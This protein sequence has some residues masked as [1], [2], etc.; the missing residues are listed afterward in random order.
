MNAHRHSLSTLLLC[1]L[2]LLIPNAPAQAGSA[3]WNLNPTSGDWHTAANWTPNTVPNGPTDIATFDV[4]TTTDITSAPGTGSIEVDSIVFNPGASAYTITVPWYL[5]EFNYYLYI[6]GTGIVNNSGVL[7]TF[8]S[9]DGDAPVFGKN[10]TAG[11]LTVFLNPAV[12]QLGRSGGRALFG[13]TSNAGSAM[14]INNG[15]GGAAGGHTEFY[16]NSSAANATIINQGSP[17]GDGEGGETF[18]FENANAGTATIINEG[19][20]VAGSYGGFTRFDNAS[21]TADATVINEG[22]SVEGAQGGSSDFLL[23]ASPGNATFIADG[24]LPG[25]AAGRIF[26]KDSS[27]GTE[28]RIELFGTGTLEISTRY[29]SDMAV[30]SLEGDGLVF[31]GSKHFIVGN[32]GLSTVFS[33][34]IQDGGVGGG[35]GGSLAKI[36]KGKLV[37][38][39]ANTYTGGTTVDDGELVINNPSGSGTGSGAVQ[40]YTGRLI[41]RGTIAGPVTVGTGGG[42]GAALGPGRRG[43]KPDSLTIQNTLTFNSDATYNCGLDTK[44]VKADQVVANSVTVNS[45]HFSL[46]S[47]GGLTL[48]SGTVLTVI[49]NIAATPIAGKFA[50][51][52]DSSTFTTHGNAFQANYEGGDGNDLTLTV[53]PQATPNPDKHR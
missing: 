5:G 29:A 52:P 1:G 41:G 20:A 15:D 16:A 33:G 6:S 4:S 44:S 28:P 50:N 34:V 21:S 36:G 35:E 30:G 19:G 42:P 9:M 13:D 26:F 37:L 53:V 39:G 22:T 51:L 25:V 7:Q 23:G 18:F 48:P 10:A 49:D 45:A 32:N 46:V 11:N 3:T 8:V 43:G 2:L 47:R 12:T 17:P 27:A 31:L 14:F 38:T 24:T 40:V